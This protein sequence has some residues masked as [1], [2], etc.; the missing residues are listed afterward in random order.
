MRGY[1][2]KFHPF[3]VLTAIF[4][5]T[6]YYK[7]LL[8]TF[9]PFPVFSP[10][11]LRYALQARDFFQFHELISENLKYH[12]PPL[13]PVI[14]SISY[15][16][17]NT[18]TI[19]NFINIL[20]SSSI[21]YPSYLL[22]RYVLRKEDALVVSCISLFGTTSFF[23]SFTTMAEN[24][25]Y[26]L[27]TLSV[28]LIIKSINEKES[29][30]CQVLCGVVISLTI[31]TKILGIILL[32]SLS[33]FILGKIISS[34]KIT[35]LKENFYTFIPFCT[36]LIPWFLYYGAKFSDGRGITSYFI[37]RHI[38]NAFNGFESIFLVVKL[39][40]IHFNIITL[41]SGVI[42]SLY[43]LAALL[44]CV[45][46]KVEEKTKNFTYFLWIGIVL[47]SVVCGVYL[48]EEQY[49]GQRYTDVWIPSILV[50]GTKYLKVLNKN[51]L[52][53]LL[54]SGT[55]LLTSVLGSGILLL[56]EKSLLYGCKWCKYRYFGF[57]DLTVRAY[58][59]FSYHRLFSLLHI[60]VFLIMF[61]II[62]IVL[63]LQKWSPNTKKWRSNIKK[64]VVIFIVLLFIISN[65]LM[66]QDY[67]AFMN[68]NKERIIGIKEIINGDNNCCSSIYHSILDEI[69][70]TP[71]EKTQVDSTEIILEKIANRK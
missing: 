24:L 6:V 61:F 40:I 23:Y 7:L 54:I 59:F 51:R 55:L 62:L 53:E 46:A 32:L 19:M 12:Y 2:K 42:F 47:T 34:K 17:Q 1:N 37:L 13:Y 21:I 18:E 15:L 49:I 25:F 26:P 60:Y 5:V 48:L 41:S 29:K 38:I 71:Q 43:A 10:D 31:L 70:Y 30:L 9:V 11:S 28:Y 57:D 4:F 3:Y 36:L 58:E 35:P 22:A 64:I 52:D 33:I 63:L 16:P 27:F 65:H 45:R 66:L 50:L 56:I 8:S 20:F 39:S 67:T 69:D 14:L 44:R 68:S